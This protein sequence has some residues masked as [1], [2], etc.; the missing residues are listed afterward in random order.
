[1]SE[2]RGRSRPLA[3]LEATTPSS[4]AA[5]ED[6]RDNLPGLG[7]LHILVATN[8]MCC[9]Q[10]TIP[11]WDD[12]FPLRFT[13]IDTHKTSQHIVFTAQRSV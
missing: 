9:N 13:P 4:P 1:M 12:R 10:G 3:S 6:L 11:S 5:V 2:G 7:R 8:S